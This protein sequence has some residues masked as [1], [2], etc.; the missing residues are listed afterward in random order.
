MDG[1]SIA[2]GLML[3]VVIGIFAVMIG[4]YFYNLRQINKRLQDAFTSYRQSLELLKQHPNNP[5]LRQKALE[6]G[7]Y[8]SSLTRDNKRVTV[9]D[10]V[11]LSND[12]SA[13]S[14]G[15]T[16]TANDPTATAVR[17][18]EQRLDQ[19]KALLDKEVISQQEYSERRAKLLNEI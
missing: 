19:L 12:I 16:Q 13:A 5:E 1:G 3:L 7:R 17:P 11:A 15:G 18:I 6:W 2:C 8:Y 14:A 9:Y 10:E 4:F